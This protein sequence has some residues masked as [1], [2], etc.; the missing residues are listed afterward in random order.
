MINVSITLNTKSFS[1]TQFMV[2]RTEV[3]S[4]YKVDTF[5]LY[6][7]DNYIKRTIGRCIPQIE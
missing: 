4:I 2:H 5:N 6:I 3:Y 1:K 7:I